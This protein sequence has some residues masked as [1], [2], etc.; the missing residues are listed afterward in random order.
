MTV[1]KV[2]QFFHEVKVELSKVVWPKFNEFVGSTLVVLLL[3]AAFAIYL[4]A[5]D[6][7]FSKLAK[8]IFKFYGRY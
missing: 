2:M 1:V 5:I 4:G 8:Y 7:G 3:I 6:L